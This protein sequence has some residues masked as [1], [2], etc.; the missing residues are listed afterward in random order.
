MLGHLHSVIKGSRVPAFCQTSCGCWRDRA[1]PERWASSP[2]GSLRGLW[3]CEPECRQEPALRCI[4]LQR[5]FPLGLQEKRFSF[6]RVLI[7]CWGRGQAYAA[8]DS[9]SCSEQSAASDTKVLQLDFQFPSSSPSQSSLFI[10]IILFI[11]FWFCWIFIA[12][13]F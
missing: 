9:E 8:P 1:S 12:A 4:S 10:V 2:H 6:P 3:L 13:P 5:T 7:T 11:Y